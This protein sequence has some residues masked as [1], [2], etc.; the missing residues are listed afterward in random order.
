MKKWPLKYQKVI[1]THLRTYLRDS[2]YSSGIS[3][4]SNN[5]DSSDSSDSYDSSDRSDSINKKNFFF[6]Y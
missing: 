6:F 1:K 3:D 4:S 5:S 2:S